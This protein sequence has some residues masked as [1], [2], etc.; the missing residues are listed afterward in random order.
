MLIEH[1]DEDD[2]DYIDLSG[3]EMSNDGDFTDED[4]DF[5]DRITEQRSDVRWDVGQTIRIGFLGGHSTIHQRVKKY[6]RIWER[7]ANIRFQFVSREPTHVR[8]S[9]F[10]GKGCHS[11]IGRNALKV[12][13]PRP[14][15]NL[16]FSRHAS[17]EEIRTTVLHE[18]GH[19]LG[20]SHEHT[21]PNARIRW[22]ESAVYTYYQKTAGWDKRKTFHNILKKASPDSIATQFDPRSIMYYRI[23]PGFTRDGF[24]T[25]YNTTLSEIDKR[26]I[27]EQYP[28][29]LRC[30]RCRHQIHKSSELHFC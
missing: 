29:P 21:S 2:D 17:E 16:G 5:E 19:V 24:S 28:Q 9:F 3:D 8:I 30:N 7:Y 12:P 11:E 20:C 23:K 6:A 22:N 4:S 27:A 10:K 14:T 25:H 15:M 13:S 18:F 1:H 26:F